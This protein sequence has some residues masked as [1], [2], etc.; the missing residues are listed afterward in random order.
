MGLGVR[1]CG[2]EYGRMCRQ[3][4][5]Q[6]GRCV[7]GV[8]GGRV[9]WACVVGVCGGSACVREGVRVSVQEGMVCRGA[10]ICNGAGGRHR[11]RWYCRALLSSMTLGMGWTLSMAL[12]VRMLVV[13]A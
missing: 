1:V 6:A 3:D 7:V 8:C 11:L 4:G 2:H 5:M 13:F 10:A 9:W 12:R